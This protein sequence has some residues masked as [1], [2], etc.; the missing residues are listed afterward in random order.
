[1]IYRFLHAA[2][3]H[4]GHDNF[5]IQSRILDFGAQL[6]KIKA[7]AIAEA[8]KLVI[9]AGDVF[10]SPNPDPWSS[11]ALRKFADD[12]CLLGI[13]IVVN[14]GNH[15][16]YPL[17]LD[18]QEITR[19]ESMSDAINAMPAHNGLQLYPAGRPSTLNLRLASL[20]WMPSSKIPQALQDLPQELDVL[21]MHQSCSGFLP[22]IAA[23]EMQLEWLAGKARYVALGDLHI[24]KELRPSENTVV[25]Y[26]GSTE[27]C[28]LS[29]S[30]IKTVNVVELD[31]E[32]R[33][34]PPVIRKVEISTRPVTTLVIDTPEALEQVRNFRPASDSLVVFKYAQEFEREVKIISN[35]MQ[36]DGRAAFGVEQSLPKLVASETFTASQETAGE[37]MSELLQRRFADQSLLAS[38]AADLWN[39]PENGA[40]ILDQLE[41]QLCAS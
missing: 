20:N 17:K 1:M 33:Q 21:V 24:S 5:G 37:E 15:D 39:N 30:L 8:V 27:M 18:G 6:E 31:L 34:A 13:H 40:E 41:T 11:K 28:S 16:R 10:N 9:L 25:A 35:C 3:L 38:A 23:C 32:N 2:D 7:I 36:A 12:L 19:V 14:T 22:S 4:L 26:P 29:E